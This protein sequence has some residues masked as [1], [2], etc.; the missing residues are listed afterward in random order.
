ME[1]SDTTPGLEEPVVK[2]G[3]CFYFSTDTVALSI[4]NTLDDI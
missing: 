4:K 1:D 3:C 2:E